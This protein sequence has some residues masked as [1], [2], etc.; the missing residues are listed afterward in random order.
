MG[1]WLAQNLDMWLP[2]RRKYVLTDSGVEKTKVE[3]C[4]KGEACLTSSDSAND[5]DG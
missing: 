2:E 3:R 1:P 4:V 5:V